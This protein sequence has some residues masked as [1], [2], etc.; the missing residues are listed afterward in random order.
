VVALGALIGLLV[1]LA[2]TLAMPTRQLRGVEIPAR[3]GQRVAVYGA[4]QP[5]APRALSRITVQRSPRTVRDALLGLIAG[6][7]AAGALVTVVRRAPARSN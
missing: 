3:P 5:Y 7:L 4:L 1:V 6:G 2:F